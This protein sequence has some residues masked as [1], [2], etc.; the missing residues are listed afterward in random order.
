MPSDLGRDRRFLKQQERIERHRRTLF[1]KREGRNRRR[2]LGRDEG[3]LERDRFPANITAFARLRLELEHFGQN[4]A[5][6]SRNIDTITS[7]TSLPTAL[8]LP[9]LDYTEHELRVSYELVEDMPSFRPYWDEITPRRA[10]FDLYQELSPIQEYLDRIFGFGEKRGLTP[11]E[12]DDHTE[13]FLLDRETTSFC[14]ISQENLAAGASCR[15]LKVCPR[16]LLESSRAHP[17]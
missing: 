16:R 2:I 3:R 7:I 17:S 5:N 4:A 15:R 10:M 6:R 14:S 1:E 12:V 9:R 8:A 13:L 11:K